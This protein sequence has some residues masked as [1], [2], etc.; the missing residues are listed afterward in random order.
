MT[1][2]PFR[3]GDLISDGK[4]EYTVVSGHPDQTM[5]IRMERARCVFPNRMLPIPDSF[6][7]SHHRIFR[8]KNMVFKLF[9]PEQWER[10]DALT[11]IKGKAA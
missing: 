11:P 5:S 1:K 6:A 8:V 10:I 7:P 3:R 9:S 2:V 4:A